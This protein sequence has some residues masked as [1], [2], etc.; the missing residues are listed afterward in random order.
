M[1][2]NELEDL[3][4]GLF[5]EGYA[6]QITKVVI[7]RLNEFDLLELVEYAQAAKSNIDSEESLSKQ[8]DDLIDELEITTK[9]TIAINEIFFNYSDSLV[10]DGFLHPLQYSH[11]NYI[12]KYS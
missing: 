7:E 12:G 8:F 11:Y 2:H 10:Q 6:T 1:I 9:D 3:L 4:T 5:E